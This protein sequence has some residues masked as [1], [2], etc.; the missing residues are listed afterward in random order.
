M[1]VF[2]AT[3]QVLFDVT[4]L[5]ISLGTVNAFKKRTV[6]V[7]NSSNSEPGPAARS[8]GSIF[9][10]P[11][12]TP[13]QRRKLLS[14]SQKDLLSLLES[15]LDI[16]FSTVKIFEEYVETPKKHIL[17]T[18]RLISK[19]Y[20][21]QDNSSKLKL[22]G[23]IFYC[24]GFTSHISHDELYKAYKFCQNGYIFFM[25]DHYGHGKSDGTWIGF[26]SGETLIDDCDYLFE[27]AKLKYGNKYLINN[28]QHNYYLMGESMGGAI[29]T[30]LAVRC[31]ERLKRSKRV[32]KTPVTTTCTG[33]NIKIDD[34]ASGGGIIINSSD[35]DVDEECKD[36][37]TLVGDHVAMEKTVENEMKSN[38]IDWNGL[39]L[40][41]PLVTVD[42]AAKPSE[43]V[44]NIVLWL[45]KTFPFLKTWQ[46]L[47]VQVKDNG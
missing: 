38:P 31:Q 17:F 8:T 22:K 45:L 11:H 19:K 24:H 23:M 36:E 21:S 32:N 26:D 39:V 40:L 4:V 33:D 29:A 41:A 43:F 27:W 9:S 47:Q 35:V 18:K 13:A 7:S 5:V 20:L 1:D 46:L 37:I 34:Q 2:L 25:N 28:N 44:I 10:L 14:N 3:L 42:E 15:E 12:D 30:L 16:D 6:A